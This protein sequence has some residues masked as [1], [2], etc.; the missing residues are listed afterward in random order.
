MRQLLLAGVLLF[1]LP[2]SLFPQ[3]EPG[4]ELTV[5]LLTFDSGGQVWERFGHNGIWIR[6]AR[7]GTDH[8][9]DYGRFSFEQKNFFLRFA[10]GKMWYSMGDTNNVEG[11]VRFYASE[12]R[13]IWAQEL[14]LLPAERLAL[15]EMMLENIRPENAG[16]AY[17][18]Y[19]DNCSTRIRD[20]LDRVV[21]GAIQRYGEAPS[22][23]TWREETRR[24]NQHNIFLYTGLM[25][26]LGQRT[27]RQM[28]RWEQMFLP[29][30]FREHLDSVSIAGPD[31]AVRRLVKTRTVLAEGGRY[32]VPDRPADWTFRYLLVGVVIGGL[33]AGLGGRFGRGAASR[34]LGVSSSRGA[35]GAAAISR[36]L[37]LALATLWMLLAGIAG[38]VLTWL[39]GFSTHLAAHRNE[40]LLL[41]N[42]LAL[43]LAVLLPLALRGRM[44]K[45]TR[46]LALLVVA[47]AAL[48][49]L[50]KVVPGFSQ[51]NLE[52]I[53]LV[54][55]VHA[56]VVAGWPRVRSPEPS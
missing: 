23:F 9:Y 49:L 18:Y 30:R 11:V 16:Y 52:L 56:G 32:P 7:A 24:L 20:A 41:F 8:L 27:D 35:V 17:D 54:L 5:T 28:S 36:Y 22:G 34:R 47:L 1:P 45:P 19:L 10:Q 39:W 4:T 51:A 29:I 21:G 6:D 15:R 46:R 37:F 14:D 2:S 12:G 3:T 55:P 44:E 26:G 31:G 43:A 42:L 13:K 53:A 25:I 38:L 50:A 48:G 33:L 40:N